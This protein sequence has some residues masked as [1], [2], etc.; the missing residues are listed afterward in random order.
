MTFKEKLEVLGLTNLPPSQGDTHSQLM[1]EELF[2]EIE[3]LAEIADWSSQ[4]DTLVG[5]M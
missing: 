4:K 1:A 3:D 5:T 2:E